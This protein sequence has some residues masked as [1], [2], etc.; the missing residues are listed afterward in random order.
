MPVLRQRPGTTYTDARLEYPP[1]GGT[2]NVPARLAAGGGT[3]TVTEGLADASEVMTVGPML[4][5]SPTLR[6]SPSLMTRAGG[7][8]LERVS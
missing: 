4:L 1:D 5:T 8:L 6:T 2:I 3:M 7:S